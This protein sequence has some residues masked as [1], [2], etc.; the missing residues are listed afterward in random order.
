MLT[1]AGRV[2]AILEL[3]WGRV[4]FTP[5][6]INLRTGDGLRKGRA[7]VPMNETIHAALLEARRAALSDHVIEWAAKPVKS[8]KGDLQEPYRSLG[9]MTCLHLRRSPDSERVEVKRAIAD[10][11]FVALHCHQIWP[12]GLEY[13]GIDIFRLKVRRRSVCKSRGTSVLVMNHQMNLMVRPGAEAHD[14][15]EGFWTRRSR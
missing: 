6:Q 12:E 7:I 10:G 8:I 4:D 13:A 11:Q 2:P 5:R 3:T 14:G 9:S 15:I 1:T